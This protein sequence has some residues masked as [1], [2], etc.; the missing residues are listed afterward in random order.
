MV[1][2]FKMSSVERI[3][4]KGVPDNWYFE[5]PTHYKILYN[6]VPWRENVAPKIDAA[7]WILLL[8]TII[9]GFLGN[10]LTIFIFVRNFRENIMTSQ[11]IIT[12]AIVDTIY[13]IGVYGSY[14]LKTGIPAIFGAKPIIMWPNESFLKIHVYNTV[15][16]A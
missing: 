2:T 13:L 16:S 15:S 8:F 3:Y 7:S 6:L 9:C 14:F 5:F 10:F 4:I 12:L 11:Y 1:I